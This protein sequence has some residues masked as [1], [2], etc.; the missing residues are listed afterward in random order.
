MNE[1]I[2]KT[3]QRSLLLGLNWSVHETARDV[4]K[5]SKEY[6]GYVVAPTEGKLS[7]GST[8]D[9]ATAKRNLI[10]GGLFVGLHCPN[11]VIEHEIPELG[12][13]WICVLQGGVPYRG[14]DQLVTPERA[15]E[16]FAEVRGWHDGD[17]ITGRT[18]GKYTLQEVL[19]IIEERIQGGE[20]TKQDL[21]A[22]TLRKAG[23]GSREMT[24][25][26]LG[27]IAL[28]AVSALGLQYRDR[29]ADA[30]KREQLLHDIALRESERKAEAARLDAAQ[31]DFQAKV[32]KQRERFATGNMLTQQWAACDDVRKSLP[33]TFQGY[34]VKRLTCDL[35][36]GTMLVEWE[37]AG[38]YVS[39][40]ARAAIPGVED[41]MGVSLP[42]RSIVKLPAIET[43]KTEPTTLDLVRAR[44]VVADW[45]QNRLTNFSLS[46]PSA[47]TLAPPADLAK[48]RG[49]AP[50]TIGQKA[51]W[52]FNTSGNRDYLMTREAVRLLA[53]YPATVDRIV[54]SQP[55]KESIAVQA[56]GALYS[57]QP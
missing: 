28:G 16:I 44:Q 37:P 30:R 1:H 32:A 21:A 10:A 8:T 26:A 9:K 23:V 11:A 22:V 14:Y 7:T 41:P 15:K 29:L 40:S 24:L 47:V 48:A 51:D 2:L 19:G 57:S 55:T 27:L 36:A 6:A 52:T 39:I 33:L 56:N 13:V 46:D 54:W 42:V 3:D 53:A 43:A 12:L 17:I 45:A 20:I 4:K 25:I 49:I 18:G 35:N 31:A 50:V 38:Q 34:E 5:A